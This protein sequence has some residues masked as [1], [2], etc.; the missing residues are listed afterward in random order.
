MN[1]RSTP[2]K[3]KKEPIRCLHCQKLGHERR[4]CKSESPKCGRCTDMHET[5]SCPTDRVTAR[6]SNCNGQHPTYDRDCPKFREKCQQINT[7]CL[8]N[9][10]AFYPMVD[11]WTWATIEQ[12]TPIEELN[13]N[14][15]RHTH[16]Q[17]PHRHPQPYRS[18][19]NNTPLGRPQHTNMQSQSSTCPQ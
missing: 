5:E 3:P 6:C 17:D 1:K 14:P 15:G 10:L 12:M 11:D 8:E 2:K 7:R 16:L 9:K 19:S 18:G 13:I 4:D